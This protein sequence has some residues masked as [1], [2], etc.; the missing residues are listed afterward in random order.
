MTKKQA[1]KLFLVF[2]IVYVLSFLIINWA[3]VSW[4]FNYRAISAIFNDFIYPYQNANA[5]SQNPNVVYQKS[6]QENAEIKKEIFVYSER[7]N[8]IRIPEINIDVPVSFPQSAD[9]GTL[10]AALDKGVI[11][12]P[13][14]ADPGENGQTIILGHS[15]PE[16]WPMIKHDW[17]FSDLNDLTEGSKVHLVVNH[18][19]FSY[20]VT[21]K[22][23]IAKGSEISPSGLTNSDSMLVLVSCWPPGKNLQRIA[24]EA[25]LDI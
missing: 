4:I 13:G 6:S 16:N 21:R 22:S 3:D 18:K 12:Y 17:V 8:S 9:L 23:I 20:T 14:S 5:D 15:A 11:V 7:E 25:K 1:K 2:G 24:V 10:S 19:Q